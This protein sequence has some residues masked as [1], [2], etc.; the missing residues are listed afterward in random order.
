ML[1]CVQGG[2]AGPS[3]SGG[4]EKVRSPQLCGKNAASA[5]ECTR[6][7]S[8]EECIIVGKLTHHAIMDQSGRVQ[9]NTLVR[10]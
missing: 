5:A 4:A 8:T 2:E 6:T 7:V 1:D 9:L 3:N 10:V